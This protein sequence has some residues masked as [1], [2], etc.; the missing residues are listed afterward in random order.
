MF[1]L[2]IIVVIYGEKTSF[3]P[4]F[5]KTNV[6][7]SSR[8]RHSPFRLEKIYD[9]RNNPTYSPNSN[10][11]STHNGFCVNYGYENSSCIVEIIIVSILIPFTFICC[12]CCY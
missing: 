1:I 12:L 9:G 7:Y 6:L 5:S 10:H 2:V 3:R 11:T 4:S 8:K